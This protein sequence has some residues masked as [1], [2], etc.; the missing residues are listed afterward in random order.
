MLYG[1]L[2]DLKENLTLF[3]AQ[4]FY[5]GDLFSAVCIALLNLLGLARKRKK[6]KSNADFTGTIIPPLKKKKIIFYFCK[7][8]KQ[9][10]PCMM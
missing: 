5:M 1:F 3:L 2:V 10:F 9:K 7:E 8:V 6:L 4:H